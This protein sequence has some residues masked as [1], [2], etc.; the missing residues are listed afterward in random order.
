MA[1][2]G[3][4]YAIKQCM[5]PKWTN[6]APRFLSGWLSPLRKDTYDPRGMLGFDTVRSLL[7]RLS[8][9]LFRRFQSAA[10]KGH[11]IN[12]DIPSTRQ[13]SSSTGLSGVQLF[14][15]IGPPITKVHMQQ[16]RHVI[17]PGLAKDHD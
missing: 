1:I 3:C 9:A 12:F 8:E 11:T 7:L 10:K 17:L 13:A 16:H 2:R 5:E 14:Q 4:L 6:V 15:R